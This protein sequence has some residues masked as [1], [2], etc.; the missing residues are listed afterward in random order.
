ML[1][2]TCRGLRSRVPFPPLDHAAPPS[3]PNE[4]FL[5]FLYP[6][7]SF[8]T[9]RNERHGSRRLAVAV[10]NSRLNS[11]SSNCCRCPNSNP[12]H[13][14]RRYTSS[15]ASTATITE[16][17][18]DSQDFT[19][20]NA[21][22]LEITSA[23]GITPK[24]RRSTNRDKDA[25]GSTMDSG[26]NNEPDPEHP[27]ERWRG[28]TDQGMWWSVMNEMVELRRATQNSPR[29]DSQKVISLVEKD[30]V[31]LVGDEGENMWF[32]TVLS[33]VKVHVRP[34][35]ERTPGGGRKV[36]LT[37]SWKAV[38]AAEKEIQV[39]LEALRAAGKGPDSV[40]P[41]VVKD[42]DTGE[43]KVRSVWTHGPLLSEGKR[44]TIPIRA[45]CVPKPKRWTVKNFA[46]YIETLTNLSYTRPV[47]AELYGKGEYH[48]VVV[49]DTI[50]RLFKDP[51]TRPFLSTRAVNSAVFY[52]YRHN[53]FL[54]DLLALFPTMEH[55][56]TTR[57]FNALLEGCAKTQDIKA[58]R[59]VISLM[60]R[61]KIKPNGMEWVC[62]LR[63]LKS[64]LAR[65]HVMERMRADGLLDKKN[66]AELVMPMNIRESFRAHLIS[67]K[68][69][70]SF[71]ARMTERHGT[72]L[73]LTSESM[74]MMLHV[75]K[76]EMNIDATEH[77]LQHCKK[78]GVHLPTQSMNHCLA[79]LLNHKKYE[80]VLDLFARLARDFPQ[81]ER[82]DET[83]R[84]LFSA[85]W[86]AQKYNAARVIWRYACL[87]G[88]VSH[89]MK[90]LAFN[91]LL[92]NTISDPDNQ[93]QLWHKNAAKLIVGMKL[94]I[95]DLD[96]SFDILTSTVPQHHTS[97]PNDSSITSLPPTPVSWL[98]QYQP[99][100]EPR[101]K[102]RAL[103]ELVI[104]SDIQTM[105]SFEPKERFE[106]ML[107]KAMRLDAEW[108][109]DGA[110]ARLSLAE[111]VRN[112]IDVP[113]V[114]TDGWKLHVRRELERR[115]MTKEEDVVGDVVREP[116][117]GVGGKVDGDVYERFAKWE[118]EERERRGKMVSVKNVVDLFEK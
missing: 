88:L 43:T 110:V 35:S 115:A 60:K 30:A 8:S 50:C 61:L 84:I 17:P 102:Q 29:P 80:E 64:K 69:V 59:Y 75:A 118:R 101:E 74:K 38:Q 93:Y 67:G 85:A 25:R 90:N 73:A 94:R 32:A 5:P 19:D 106:D 41:F 27:A 108:S 10:D 70:Q 1:P 62:F 63:L 96:S 49:K 16:T 48:H 89:G 116:A 114:D 92:R 4:P 39:A 99:S 51:R 37:G 24:P 100:G 104:K 105:W 66:I 40:S 34:K 107:D 78:M 54:K 11:A 45:D 91:S 47:H 109:R 83:F 72:N 44:P 117:E 76:H 87:A 22:E 86:K 6:C 21:D 36:V 79:V 23:L 2:A 33:G 98:M 14:S 18:L 15:Q 52:F 53:Q 20:T 68:D 81:T 9:L 28:K 13:V 12:R 58:F 26:I 3:R 77:I 103:A 55:L 46:D 97:S 31:A 112:A 7:I 95:S 65:K 111:L 113:L 57:T 71:I 82:N 56:M 42:S